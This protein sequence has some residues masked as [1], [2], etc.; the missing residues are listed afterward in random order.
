MIDNEILNLWSTAIK[1]CPNAFN[2]TEDML[3]ESKKTFSPVEIEDAT[4]IGRFLIPT[5]FVRYVS[6]LQTRDK[7]VDQG[8]VNDIQ[9]IYEVFGVKLDRP[10]PICAYN[11]EHPHLPDGLSGHH[12]EV[13]FSSLGQGFYI[14]DLYDFSKSPYCE[15]NKEEIRST[16]NHHNDSFS[17][18]TKHDDLKSVI[19]SLDRGLVNKTTEDITSFV[20]KIS[21]NKTKNVQNWIIRNAESYSGVFPNFRTYSAQRGVNKKNTIA[22][23][24]HTQG[25]PPAGIENRTIQEIQ[26]NGCI[27]YAAAEGDNMSTWA[28]AVT[29]SVKYNVPVYI[30]GYSTHRIDDLKSFRESW[31]RSFNDQKDIMFEFASTIV[32]ETNSEFDESNFQV[33]IGGFLPQYVKANPQDRGAPT[34]IGFVDAEGK[35]LKFKNTNVCLSS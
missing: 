27:V 19:S 3:E 15:R 34:E 13:V 5:A 14:Y 6:E 35:T 29:N 1:T 31:I 21:A 4:Y 7:K 26:D 12:R 30:F 28:R 9:N 32:K 33:K 25:I 23:F 11:P 22:N 17:I 18:Q 10:V 24:F 2:I 8:Q 16:S 20:R